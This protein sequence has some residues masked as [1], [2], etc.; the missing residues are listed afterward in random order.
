MLLPVELVRGRGGKQTK[1]YYDIDKVSLLKW[2]FEF[3]TVSKPIVKA[4]RT[5]DKFKQWM[6]Q[7]E[8]YT[9]YDFKEWASSRFKS[10]RCSLFIADKIYE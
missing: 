5:W 6:I 2:R 10:S 8:F 7:R 4:K 9:I 1:A 3:L